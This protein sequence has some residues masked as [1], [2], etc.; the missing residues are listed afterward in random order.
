MPNTAAQYKILILSKVG[1]PLTGGPI[2]GVLDAL[3][4]MYADK[5]L[6]APRLQYFY[7]LAEAYDLK[8]GAI[9]DGAY[10]PVG[11]V[12]SKALDDRVTSYRQ[13]KA[14]VLKDI[15]RLERGYN[16]VRPVVSGTL[17]T[18]APIG[19]ADD[20]RTIFAPDANDR[21]F[22]GDAYLGRP[23]GSGRII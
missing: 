15:A 13:L 11:V 23:T 1:E 3:W 14:D 6:I 17:T 16:Q 8:I 22:R 21:E 19:P 7:V 12:Q 2:T 18:T 10:M 20:P 9:Q 4:D 5:A